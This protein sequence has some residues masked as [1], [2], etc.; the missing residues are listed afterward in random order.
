MKRIILFIKKFF[1]W[2]LSF[3]FDRNKTIKKK[4]KKVVAKVVSKK[5]SKVVSKVAFS[6]R[7]EDMGES[8]IID[9]YPYTEAK[10]LKSIDELIEKLSDKVEIINDEHKEEEIK[11][12]KEIKEAITKKV[13][14]EPLNVSQE[15]DIKEVLTEAIND[16]EIHID[17]DQKIRNIQKEI[18]KVLDKKIN[19]HDKDIIEKAYYKYEKVNYVVATT[20]EIEE[21]EQDLKDLED[22]VKRGLHK[23]SYY[24]DKIK[25]IEKKINRLRKINKNPKVYDELE[26]L[27]DDFYTKSIDKY[28]LLYT[29]EVFVNL[30]KQCENIMDYIDSKELEEEKNETDRKEKLEENRTKREL[31]REEERKLRE[32]ERDKRQRKKEEFEDNIIKRYLDLKMANTI[33]ATNLI[34]HRERMKKGIIKTLEDD[35]EDFLIG[36]EN[37]FN[38][39][40]NKQKTEVCKLYNNLLEVLCNEQKT[41]FTPVE[42][43]NYQY[44]TLLEDTIATK[45]AVER[46]AEKKT[47]NDIMMSPKSVAVSDKLDNELKKEKVKNEELGIKDKILVRKMK[48][49]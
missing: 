28:D 2:I 4:N 44:Q 40:R 46:L 38:F 31:E 23:R 9:V 11:V 17:T 21:L 1:A 8:H 19:K 36:E 13:D 7:D 14:T 43:I 30:D 29:K 5:G 41:L 34:V 37:T 49:E 18:D 25:E 22:S 12:I 32:Q 24:E 39:D 10:D 47:G 45:D 16:K 26:R 3:F 33:L 6:N 42:H 15:E 27:K 48:N 20:M 35:Y